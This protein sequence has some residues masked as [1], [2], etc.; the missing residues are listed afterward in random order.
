M[1]RSAFFVLGLVL[2]TLADGSAIAQQ[3]DAMPHL[4]GSVLNPNLSLSQPATTPLQEQIQDNYAT[5]L[6]AGQRDLLQQ[7]PS[8][9]SRQELAIGRELNGFIP[10]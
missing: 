7:N 1:Y 10:R 8:G 4:G 5:D 6:R 9:Y 2:A 3:R